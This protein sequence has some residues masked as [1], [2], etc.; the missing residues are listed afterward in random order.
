MKT[1]STTLGMNMLTICPDTIR[2]ANLNKDAD[3]G[4]A[5]GMLTM[6][7]VSL[8]TENVGEGM[9]GDGKPGEDM[10]GEGM[11]GEGGPLRCRPGHRS[12]GDAALR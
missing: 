1:R 9:P 10:P 7:V 5:G 11:P 2:L 8:Y 3:T 6:F 4:G 12:L